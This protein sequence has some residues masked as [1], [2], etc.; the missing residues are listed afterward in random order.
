ML[1]AALDGGDQEEIDG[2]LQLMKLP[3]DTTMRD[4][5]RRLQQSQET[6]ASKTLKLTSGIKHPRTGKDHCL[7]YHFPE[8]ILFVGQGLPPDLGV[9]WRPAQT[10]D[11][12][13]SKAPVTTTANHK[14]WH[15]RAGDEQYAIKE[16][17][18]G[19]ASHLQTCLKEAAVI[20]RHRHP[21]IV[22]VK[23]IFQGS[24]AEE[25]NFYLQMPWY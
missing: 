3:A 6:L 20:Y 24:G 16:Y 2:A 17:A 11:S 25:G 14:V 15:V 5:R 21:H 18:A 22:E 10:L 8:V 12:F 7:Q 13:D 9:L 23:A 19:Q 4:L 1:A